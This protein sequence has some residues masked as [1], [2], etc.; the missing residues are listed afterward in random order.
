MHLRDFDFTLPSDLIAQ[1]PASRR[2]DSRL[3]IVDRQQG[4]IQHDV[5]ANVGNYL[6]AGDVLVVND[7][8]VI[9]ARLRG[10]KAGTGGS[11]EVLLLHE[12]GAGVWEVLLRPAARTPDGVE[13]EF[14]AG[15]LRA[16]VAERRQQ[17]TT[18]LHFTPPD[19]LALLPELG[20]VPLPPYIKRQQRAESREFDLERYQTVYARRPGAVAAPTAGLHFTPEVLADLKTRGVQQATLTLHV[21]WGT[22]QPVRNDAIEEHRMGVERYELKAAEAKRIERARELGN[23]VVA[24]GTTTTRTLETIGQE[25]GRVSAENGWSEL[26]IKPGHRFRVIDA[27]ITNFHLP[28][29]TLFMLVCAFAGRDLMLEAYR[30]AVANQYRFY[31]YGD[32]MLIL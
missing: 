19:I 20:E 8:K 12:V 25:T 3:M 14:G 23:R 27:L 2:D 28:R 17:G 13:V 10:R 1:I 15:R 32:A 21:G 4:S 5:F 29:S 26:F 24:V 11:V 7:T 6:S 18:V 22:F 9:P 31:S 16:R 30:T